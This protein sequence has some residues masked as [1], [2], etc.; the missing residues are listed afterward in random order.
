MVKHIV[1]VKITC[2][3][4]KV[5]LDHKINKLCTYILKNNSTSCSSN[6]V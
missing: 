4:G 2:G 1:N 3:L 6:N 5:K